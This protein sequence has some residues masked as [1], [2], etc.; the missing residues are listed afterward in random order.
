MYPDFLL[1]IVRTKSKS[2][3]LSLWILHWY[4]LT[5]QEFLEQ[6]GF[7]IEWMA[8]FFPIQ[9][10]IEF[11]SLHPTMWERKRENESLQIFYLNLF[12]W[13]FHIKVCCWKKCGQVYLAGYVGSSLQKYLLHV[14]ITKYVHPYSPLSIN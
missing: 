12:W 4:C 7:Q 6:K 3:V 5:S 1:K 2:L 8:G 14:N 11:T 13:L 10:M 9:K